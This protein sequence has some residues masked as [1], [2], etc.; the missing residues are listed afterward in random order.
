MDK[1]LLHQD[2][3]LQFNWQVFL[4]TKFKLFHQIRYWQH[5]TW[6]YLH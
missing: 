4:Q 1:I 2:V 5:G 3:K 6:E